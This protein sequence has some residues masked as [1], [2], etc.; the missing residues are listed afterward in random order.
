MKKRL[1]KKNRGASAVEFAII[2][3][4]LVLLAFGIIELG[5]LLY[6]Q[7]MI[8]NASREGARIG[9]VFRNPAVTDAEI[10]S[11]VNN[12]LGTHLITFGGKKSP[13]SD[14]VTGAAVI[15]TRNGVSPG[16]ELRVKVGYTYSFLVLPQ[17]A[18]G[19]GQGIN[20]AAE[21]VMRME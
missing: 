14:P 19:V 18:L 10:S 6:D 13:S 15:V 11:V 4:L 9:I 21:T 2:L 8:T 5:F 1:L 20:M 3:P 12:Y 17:F 16:G 7:A